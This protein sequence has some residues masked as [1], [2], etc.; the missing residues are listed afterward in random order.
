MNSYEAGQS[1]GSVVLVVV[2]IM[3]AL[4]LG[5]SLYKRKKYPEQKHMHPV[6]YW[7]LF[8]LGVLFV[9]AELLSFFA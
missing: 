1:T 3:V 2:V 6:L 9:L 7:I 4:I 8:T 5:S